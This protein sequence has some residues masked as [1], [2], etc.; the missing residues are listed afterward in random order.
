MNLFSLKGKVAIVTGGTGALGQHMVKTLVHA[1]AKVAVL[2]RRMEQVQE[3]VA[4]IQAQGAEALALCADVLD[5]KALELAKEEVLRHYH[6]IDVL[7]NAAGGNLAGATIGVGQIFFDLKTEDF[8]KVLDLN[9]MGTV[10]PT[11]VFA[12]AM[13][14]QKS[15]VIVNLSSVAAHLPLT[16]VV[17]YA[18]SKAAVDN[19]TR[20]MAVELAMKYGEG[21]RVNAIAPGFFLGEQN[22]SLLTNT[23]G[24]LS[25]RG[26]QIIAHTPMKRFG[27]PNDLD[28]AL[29]FLCSDAARFVTGTVVYVDGGF[30]AYSG[31]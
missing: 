22:R 29:L 17:G 1:G 9:L 2:G 27:N 10:L 11:Q 28:G 15:G 21:L 18:A 5:R 3:L 23:D 20:Y 12:E 8:R 26:Y 19:F 4:E 7:I 31:V 6:K 16:R 14:Q 24:S 13:V 25:D 30:T